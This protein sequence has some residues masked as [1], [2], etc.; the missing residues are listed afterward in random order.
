[1]VPRRL[2]IGT[3]WIRLLLITLSKRL[4]V[5]LLGYFLQE[6]T[7]KAPFRVSDIRK[8]RACQTENSLVKII[9]LRITI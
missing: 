8:C 2:H 3:F 4:R 7:E 1:M 9:F 6:L 5:R